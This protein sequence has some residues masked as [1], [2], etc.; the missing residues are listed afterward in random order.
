SNSSMSSAPTITPSLFIRG[1]ATTT[2]TTP[3]SGSPPSNGYGPP[4]PPER[5]PKLF[6]TS[7]KTGDGVKEIFEYVARR[8]VVRQE[9]EEALEART[10]HVQEAGQ[11]ASVLLST[12]ASVG[13]RW[14]TTGNSCCSS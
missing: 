6:F 14:G 5:Y 3:E 8:V 12:P 13:R 1:Q 9:Y 2:A 11:R 4:A 7:A 10:M